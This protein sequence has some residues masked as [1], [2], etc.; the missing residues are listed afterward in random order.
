MPIIEPAAFAIASLVSDG[1]E[2]HLTPWVLH[3]A[4]HLVPLEATGVVHFD[5]AN[6]HRDDQ[7]KREAVAIPL[8]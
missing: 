4:L 5:L 3:R 8:D 7:R 2:R 1:R 6:R